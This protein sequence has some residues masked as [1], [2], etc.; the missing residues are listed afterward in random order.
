MGDNG[1]KTGQ[2][3]SPTLNLPNALTVLRI[4]M[5]PVFLWLLLENTTSSRWW[6][7]L[8]FAVAAY[9]DHLDGQIA[10]KYK[11]IT[12][13]GKLADPLADKFLTLGAFVALS[14]L[15]DLPWWFTII[16][17]VRELGITVLREVL[18]R[19]G[20]VVAAS[21]GGKLKTVLQM[22]LIMLLIIP[23]GSFV[24]HLVAQ[25]VLIL[26]WVVM[27]AALIVTVWS[28]IQYLLVSVHALNL[29]KGDEA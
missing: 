13:F 5:V 23:W 22:F 7:A 20:T 26:I 25:L 11:I 28:G 16:V 8:V 6:A 3:N 1:K 14:I 18:R 15:S 2:Q 24:S 9:T 29:Q 19:R 4:L 21:S 12:N 17:A 27:L 10:R